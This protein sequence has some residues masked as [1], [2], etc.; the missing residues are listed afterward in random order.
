M[1]LQ[2]TFS[3]K[4]KQTVA[5]GA[6][7]LAKLAEDDVARKPAPNR[8][9]KKEILGHLIDS[10]CNNHQRFVRAQLPETERAGKLRFP[11]YEQEGWA[12][13]Q[14]YAHADW[15]ALVQLWRAYNEHLARIVTKI[16]DAKLEVRCWFGEM[17]D[18]VTLGFLIEDYLAHM[19]H[20]LRQ[21]DGP[22]V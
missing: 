16:P 21:L 10:A 4:L 2:E 13:C 5:D 17:S 8:W 14:D 19:Q 11:D 1:S 12:R 6:A 20:H 9:S 18:A 22:R 7:R 15:Q 3:R